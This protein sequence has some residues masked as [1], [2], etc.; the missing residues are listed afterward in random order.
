MLQKGHKCGFFVDFFANKS[1]TLTHGKSSQHSAD[2]EAGYMAEEEESHAGCDDQAGHV[3]ADFYFRIGFACDIFHFPWEQI[4]WC[5]WQFAA[6]GKGDT[7][8]EDQITCCKI[9]YPEGNGKRQ[10]VDPDFMDIYHF[11]KSK[12]C[13]K[14]EQ[15]AGNKSL[16]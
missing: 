10:S 12:P 15:I 5:D 7:E 8:A 2:A 1:D 14:A 6:V 16:F 13:Y 3:V 9:K 4:G 11:S